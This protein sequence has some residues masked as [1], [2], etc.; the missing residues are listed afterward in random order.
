MSVMR[1]DPFR[2][3]DQLAEQIA[4]YVVRREA[5]RSMPTGAGTSS[6]SISICPESTRTRSN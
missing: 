5:S 4:G 6:S 1:F 2:D 3:Y